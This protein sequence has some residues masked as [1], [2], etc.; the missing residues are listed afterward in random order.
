M[1]LELVEDCFGVLCVESLAK[2]SAI[3]GWAPETTSRGVWGRLEDRGG[4]EGGGFEKVEGITTSAGWPGFL[5][6][7]RSRETECNWTIHVRVLR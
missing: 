6:L 7:T 4:G 1:E 3:D 5:G 2:Y